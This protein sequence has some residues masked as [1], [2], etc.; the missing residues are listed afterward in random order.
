MNKKRK[1]SQ[2]KN[3]KVDRIN[4][5]IIKGKD[6]RSSSGIEPASDFL[7]FRAIIFANP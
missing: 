7:A 5:R 1:E 3:S 4:A 6:G 2:R